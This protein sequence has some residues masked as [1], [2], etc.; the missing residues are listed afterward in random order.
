MIIRINGTNE[1][2]WIELKAFLY[3]KELMNYSRERGKVIRN[4]EKKWKRKRI[5]HLFKSPQWR[6]SGILSSKLNIRDCYVCFQTIS[7]C[8]SSWISNIV[9]NGMWLNDN[10]LIIFINKLISRTNWVSDELTF[11]ASD[12]DVAPDSPILFQMECDS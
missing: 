4:W 10:Q 7:Q 2:N 1:R 12:N 11:N 5:F 9:P 8:F 6:N 3:Y